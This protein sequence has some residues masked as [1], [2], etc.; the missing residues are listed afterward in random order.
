MPVEICNEVFRNLFYIIILVGLPIGL[1]KKIKPL[2][3]RQA[4][5]F[6][7]SLIGV[8]IILFSGLY[9]IGVFIFLTFGIVFNMCSY[10]TVKTLYIKKDCSYNTII[11]RNF[12][13]G[14]YDSDK[15]KYE[16]INKVS[17]LSVIQLV[18]TID[19]SKINKNNWT[20]IE[21]AVK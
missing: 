7:K 9:L 16:I 13:C 14:A 5:S 8:F 11:V 3:V 6:L 12:D 18:S 20:K 19:T 4:R 1:Y 15:P 21:T 17:I 2:Y 10:S